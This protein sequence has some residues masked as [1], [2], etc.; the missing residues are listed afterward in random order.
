MEGMTTPR[1]PGCQ[2]PSTPSRRYGTV[3]CHDCLRAH[4]HDLQR[5][6]ARDLAADPAGRARRIRSLLEEGLPVSAAGR[7]VGLSRSR[8]AQ[9]LAQDTP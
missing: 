9:I 8:T 6:Q 3:L 4:H 7:A 5:A 2:Q 1:C